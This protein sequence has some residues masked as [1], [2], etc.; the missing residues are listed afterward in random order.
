MNEYMSNELEYGLYTHYKGEPYKVFTIA[1]CEKKEF[2]IYQQQYGKQ[3][4]WIRPKEDF[5]GTV[6]DKG[7]KKHRFTK[8]N[9]KHEKLIEGTLQLSRMLKNKYIQ[10]IHSETHNPYSVS[11]IKIINNTFEVEVCQFN[12]NSGSFLSDFQIAYRLGY[13]YWK[14]NDEKI[15]TKLLSE[16]ELPDDQRI[17]LHSENNDSITVEE[18]DDML[19]PCSID[20]HISTEYYDKPRHKTIDVESVSNSQESCSLWKKCKIHPKKGLLIKPNSS[21]LTHSH[22]KI[23]IPKDCAGK[24]VIKSTFARLLL[25]V[26]EGDFCNPGWNGYFPLEIYNYGNHSIRIYPTHKIK[27][28]Q[29]LLIPI[30]IPVIHDYEKKSTYMNDDGTP[31]KFWAAKTIKNFRGKHG[32]S[33]NRILKFHELMISEYEAEAEMQTRFEDT[34]LRYCDKRITN[35]DPQSR[36]I[37]KIYKGYIK[38]EKIYHTLRG[39]PGKILSGLSVGISIFVGLISGQITLDR[40]KKFDLTLLLNPTIIIAIICLTVLLLLILIPSTTY[41]I[42]MIGKQAL[43]KAIKESQKSDS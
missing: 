38:R 34:F 39:L 20:L 29:L 26:T 12:V 16:Q 5:L 23:T 2:V 22:E 43:T 41:C 19:N 15:L 35:S 36:D 6:N 37:E 13:Y 24:I 14:L 31:Y 1:N 40:I 30:G 25:K 18:I 7:N 9:E 11:K 28:L 33:S 10:L 32:S 21:F 3:T 42:K 27:M 8:T 17:E 4:F